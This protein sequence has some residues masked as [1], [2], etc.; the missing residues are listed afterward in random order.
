MVTGSEYSHIRRIPSIGQEGGASTAVFVDLFVATFV[1]PF[2]RRL[3]DTH[4]FRAIPW[5]KP[6]A[7]I[8]RSLR[9]PVVKPNQMHF[10]YITIY[11]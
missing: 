2:K 11:G 8:M 4:C 7:T 3:R 10:V 5:L 6:T 9:D 1:A